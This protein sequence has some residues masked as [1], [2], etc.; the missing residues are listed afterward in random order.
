MSI[1]LCMQGFVRF[2]GS[3]LVFGFGNGY[4]YILSAMGVICM[5]WRLGE[6]RRGD[7]DVLGG[8]GAVVGGIWYDAMNSYL[9]LIYIYIYIYILWC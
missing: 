6:L 2:E 3:I 5:L 9:L 1:V 4:G 7:G 8:G